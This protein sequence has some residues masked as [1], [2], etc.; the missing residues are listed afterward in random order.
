MG[1]AKRS[2]VSTPAELKLTA[3][4]ESGHTLAVVYTPETNP[5]HK[6]TILPR[7]NTG[8]VTFM[9]PRD[10][11]FETREMILADIDVA[12]GGRVAEELV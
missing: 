7:G 4:H 5:L 6:V 2:R 11:Q 3:F 1:P 9:L 10:E 8:G 12:M